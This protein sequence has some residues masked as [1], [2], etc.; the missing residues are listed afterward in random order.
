MKNRESYPILNVFMLLIKDN[1]CTRALAI[2]ITPC[3]GK[4]YHHG[5]TFK[6]TAALKYLALAKSK[7]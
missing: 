1:Y 4:T 2:F 5:T 7:I 6:I 3:T